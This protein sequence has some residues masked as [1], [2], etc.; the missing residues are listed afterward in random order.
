M[1]VT[2]LYP[3]PEHEDERVEALQS[4]R[5]LDTLPENDFEELTLLA[6]EICQ[7]PVALIT[8]LD[9]KRQWFKSKLGFEPTQT[10]KEQAFCAHTIVNAAD[11]MVVPDARNDERFSNNPLVTG[12][13][14]I[15][16]YA[17][18]PLI[19]EDGFAL[20]SL[21]VIDSTPKDLSQ[22]QRNSLKILGKQ[23]L[24]QMELRRKVAILEKANNDLLET[25]AFIQKFASTAAHDIKNP[26]SSILLTSQALHMRLRKLNDEQSRNLAEINITAAKR[27]LTL[28]DDMLEYSSAP[29]TLLNNQKCVKMNALLKGVIA[30]IDVPHGV[31]IKLPKIDHNITCSSIALEQVFLNLINNA[32]RYNDKAEGVIT[33]L[34]REEGDYY[35][36][37]VADN[38]MGIAE[39]NLAKIFHK[40]VTLNVTDRFDKK[41]TGLGLYTVKS[42]IEKLHGQINVSSQIGSGTTFE[43]SIRKNMEVDEVDLSK[44]KS[45]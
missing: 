39:K 26:L 16:F 5:L 35:H 22:R 19:N 15:V 28:V 41:G 17:G 18:V 43:F 24:A 44:L 25:N 10:P 11:I 29:A 42:L 12:S 38:G 3:I 23:V 27:L 13:P 8:L 6:S 33:V 34:F 1:I 21:C 20:G 14:N 45:V 31:T 37:K 2:N 7:T 36:F 30:L 40:E 32:I 4:Y 9:E